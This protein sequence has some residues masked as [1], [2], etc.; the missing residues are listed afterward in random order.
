MNDLIDFICDNFTIF[1]FGEY[2]GMK[3]V[4]NISMNSLY[5]LLLLTRLAIIE[6][7]GK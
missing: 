6:K 3:P 4:D 2:G 5:K 7:N 1:Y